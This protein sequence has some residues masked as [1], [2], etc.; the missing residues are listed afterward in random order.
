MSEKYS[1]QIQSILQKWQKNVFGLAINQIVLSELIDGTFMKKEGIII[2]TLRQ[3]HNIPVTERQII[4]SGK[5]GSIYRQTNITQNISLVDKIIGATSIITNYPIITANIND[6]PQPYFE[7]ID[8]HK[9]IHK[10][11]LIKI[12]L[13]KPDYIILNS[14]FAGRK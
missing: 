9:L 4:V 5:L 11:K 1:T 8:S 7:V 13:I 2:D 12:G 3:Y 10:K 6:Y 14:A